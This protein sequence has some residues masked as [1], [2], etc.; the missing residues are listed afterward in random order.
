MGGRDEPPCYV[1]TE[2][3]TTEGLFPPPSD[4]QGV[5]EAVLG[6]VSLGSVVILVNLFWPLT[7]QRAIQTPPAAVSFLGRG[8]MSS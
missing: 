5:S 7:G 1:G 3:D 6:I 4:P 2:V 8:R